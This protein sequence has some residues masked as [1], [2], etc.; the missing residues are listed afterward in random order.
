MEEKKKCSLILT[1]P[2]KFEKLALTIGSAIIWRNLWKI[3]TLD[4]SRTPWRT[5]FSLYKS[6]NGW[7]CLPFPPIKFRQLACRLFLRQ[8]QRVVNFVLPSFF[9]FF[10]TNTLSTLCFVRYHSLR[11]KLN[12]LPNFF[13][14]F[15]D[16]AR[17]TCIFQC[18]IPLVFITV[19]HLSSALKEGEC[20]GNAV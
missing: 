7:N 6:G 8:S 11:V 5:R 12:Y 16:M 9:I 13:S 3:D 10:S 15:T 14:N 4:L 1:S 2:F 17:S 18:L 20:E 19:L